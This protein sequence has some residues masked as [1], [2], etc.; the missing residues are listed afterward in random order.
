MDL[1]NPLAKS[2]EW[3]MQTAI[4]CDTFWLQSFGTIN[5]SLTDDKICVTVQFLLCVILELEGSFQVQGP[6][7]L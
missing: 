5:N 6:G 7:G 4:Y 3:T 1:G 2:E